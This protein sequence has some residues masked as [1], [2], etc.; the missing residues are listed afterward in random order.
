MKRNKLVLLSL[1]L[2]AALFSLQATAHD[3]KFKPKKE[4]IE[5][6][7]RYYKKVIGTTVTS[8][9]LLEI[10]E[11]EGGENLFYV[12][13]LEDENPILQRDV[14]GNIDGAG[15]KVYVATYHYSYLKEKW[16]IKSIKRYTGKLVFNDDN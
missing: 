6:I 10:V 13:F 3:L 15:S 9:H 2:T 8:V 1:L 4:T 14:D 11:A 5:D 7:K 16:R 12:Y